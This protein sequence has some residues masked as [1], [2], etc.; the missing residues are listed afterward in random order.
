MGLEFSSLMKKQALVFQGNKASPMELLEYY[1]VSEALFKGPDSRER[2][3]HFDNLIHDKQDLWPMLKAYN[4]EW[5]SS[6]DDFVEKGFIRNLTD[7]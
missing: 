1:Y 3:D 5:P 7:E 6:Y 2:F 4:I